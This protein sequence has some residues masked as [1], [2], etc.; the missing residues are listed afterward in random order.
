MF[1]TFALL[2]H[3]YIHIFLK[4]FEISNFY[5]YGNLLLH[6]TSGYDQDS[7]LLL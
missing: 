7:Y 3:V 6:K 2:Q 5:R 4:F 1:A